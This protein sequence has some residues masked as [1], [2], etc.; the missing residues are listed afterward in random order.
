MKSITTLVIL[1]L[2]SFSLQAQLNM[3]LRGQVSYNPQTN[4]IWGYADDQG[5]EFALVGLRTGVSIVNVTNPDDPTEVAFLPGASSTWRDIKTWGTN[6]YVTNETGD[7]LMVIDLSMLPD[8]TAA[9]NWE[10][11]IPDLGFYLSACHNI[12]IDEFG[13]AYL[14]GCNL[15]GGG[16]IYL[17]VDTPD[18]TPEYIDH[19]PNENSH[20]IY[21]RNNLAYSSEIW[22]G[23]FTIYDVTDK[24]NTITLG[25]QQTPASTTHNAWLSDDGNYLFTTDETGNAPI[26]SYDV[27]DPSDI[28]EL[29]QFR[30]FETL[31]DGV[32]PHNVHVWNDWIIASYYSDGCIVLDGSQP[33]NL[34]EVGNFDTWF[35]GGTGFNGAWGAYPFLP[36]E[37]VLVTDQTNGLFVMT[38]N[39][40]RAARIEGLIF[41]NSNN[42]PLSNAS[43]AIDGTT[44]EEF[45]AIDGI[46]KT[47]YHTGGTYDFT[48]SKYGYDSKTISID[49][50]NDS[51]VMLNVGLDPLMS[52][53]FSANVTDE[54]NGEALPNASITLSN[55]DYTFSTTTNDQ[56]IANF[57]AVFEGTYNLATGKWGYQTK[58]ETGINISSGTANPSVALGAG[59]EDI[60]S[61]DLG[62][63]VTGD[64]V[65]GDWELADPIGEFVSQ[66]GGFFIAPDEDDDDEGSGAFVTDNE[67]PVRGGSTT[68]TSPVFD[69]SN[70][71][72]PIVKYSTWFFSGD[73]NT[74]S[75]GEGFMW[76]RLTNG[77]TTTTVCLC[78]MQELS[79]PFWEVTEIDVKTYLE[80]T[81]SMQIIFQIISGDITEAGV[82]NFAAWDADLISSTSN[83]E[84]LITISAEPNP[85][86][87]NFNVNWNRSFEGQGT[88]EIFSI[89][90]QPIERFDVESGQ[91]SLQL[92][93]DYSNGIYLAQFS[94]EG[95]IVKTIKLIKH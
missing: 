71:G 80:P 38:P 79:I 76:V 11:N 83:I 8:S 14:S 56:G 21:V 26:G 31:D 15:N 59:Y 55:D 67:D 42:A 24:S 46:Y 61:V 35:G 13:I 68:L 45:T 9:Y 63:E 66:A 58:I 7:G 44:T 6:A 20:D 23:V 78:K 48:F 5:N 30:P 85:S 3:T 72:K 49:I 70:T 27:S 36:S 75:G 10:P 77:Y 51:I 18:G 54:E 41:D 33:D 47:G 40:V 95:K 81:D 69:L 65:T 2:F 32:V 82:D 22:N 64:P 62:W 84:E 29:D 86:A 53:S 93:A 16:L 12:F 91:R 34:I 39:Y 60:F 88:L 94:V 50:A 25:S 37:T 17:D 92:G 28:I 19:G 89:L 52:Y 57:D 90:G 74:M 1:F 4:D 73:L 87:N 43:A